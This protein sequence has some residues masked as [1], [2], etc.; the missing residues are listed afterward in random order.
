MVLRGKYE[1]ITMKCDDA[2]IREGGASSAWRYWQSFTGEKEQ[3]LQR[4]PRW[5]RIIRRGNSRGQETGW[6]TEEV[7]RELQGPCC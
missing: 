1:I 7:F 3:E 5:G 4:K 6:E 2:L